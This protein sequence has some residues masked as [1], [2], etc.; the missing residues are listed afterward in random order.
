MM[1][2][3]LTN[4]RAIWKQ[5]PV[6]RLLYTDI[7][8]RIAGSVV[9]GPTLELGGG[10]GN[11][12]E[13]IASLIS[14]DIQFS[15]WLDLVT[16]AQKLPFSAGSLSNIVMLDVIH[17]IEFPSLFF[18][19]A[20]RVLRSGGRIVMVEPGITFGSTLFY[21]MLHHEPVLMNVDPLAEGAPDH[22]RNP[23]DSNQA[24]PTLLATRYREQFHAKFADLRIVDVRW[25]SFLA[26]P[27]SGGFKPWS[28]I[29][30]PVARA[31]LWF[32][33]RI[34][35]LCGHLFGFRLLI[36][37]EKTPRGDS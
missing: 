18:K 15:P 26:Y 27:L 34:E 8:E 33:K 36:V 32:E 24:I 12:K 17:H 6:L 23:Y 1:T 35:R 11:L 19:E 14:S 31:V 13:K 22:R 16:D 30:E 2:E 20:A 21:R 5:K 10:I 29:S 4:Y 25:F 37:I 3:A 28:L 7:F 9:D